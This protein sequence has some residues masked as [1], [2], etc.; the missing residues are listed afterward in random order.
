MVHIKVKKGLDIPIKGK[1]EGTLKPLIPGGEVSPLHIPSKIALNLSAFEDVKFRLLV[2]VGDVVKIGQPLA[3][4]KSTEGRMFVSPA[5][6]VV[7]DIQRGD[8]RVLLAIVI[9]VAKQEDFAEL[10]TLDP[11][12]ASKDE[13]LSLLKQ[14]GAFANIRAR[15][16][17]LLADPTKP[18]K[19]IFVKAIESAPFMPPA[20]LQVLGHEKE[21]QEGLNALSK[22]TNGKVHLVYRQDTPCKAFTEAKNVEKHTAEGPHPVA[23]HSL[24]IQKIDRIQAPD[25]WIWTLNTHD[26]ISIGYLLTK[27]RTFTEKVISIAGPGVLPDR[28]GYFKVRNGCPINDLISGRIQKAPLR[29][30][31]GDPLT[32]HKV[33]TEDFLG[34]YDFIFSVIPENT[35]REFLHFFG[36]GLNKYTFS[37]AYLTG[38]FNNQDREY[39]FTTNQHGEHRAFIDSTLYDKVMP[40]E[41]P[42]MLLVKA[43]LSED[44]ELADLYGLLEVDSE[45]FALPTFVCPSK[46]EMTQIIKKGL[47]QYA[48]EI[49]Q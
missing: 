47:K 30:I 16:F 12:H 40:L 2:K 7:S 49:L 45:D 37:K 23:N 39:N 36:L 34:Y 41:V 4:D 21:F 27:G 42:T 48:K 32:G 10:P 25:Q 35:K 44:F 38:H 1:P 46:M 15:P 43:V 19:S 31:S 26:V 29:F 14:G 24:H 13:I 28:V 20:E 5:S 8:K 3:E 18:P 11:S 22:L 9:D 33:S 6:G 17:N